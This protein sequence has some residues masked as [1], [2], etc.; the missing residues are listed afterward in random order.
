MVIESILAPGTDQPEHGIID[1]E[2]GHIRRRFEERLRPEALAIFRLRN[3]TKM[4]FKEIGQKLGMKP[5]SISSD[6]KRP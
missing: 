6:G 2:Y 3:H 4:T 5:G 1:S